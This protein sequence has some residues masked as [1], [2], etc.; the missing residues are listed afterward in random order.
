MGQIQDLKSKPIANAVIDVWQAGDDG[1][2][3]SL[4]FGLKME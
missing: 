3:S 2:Y 4:C 1:L